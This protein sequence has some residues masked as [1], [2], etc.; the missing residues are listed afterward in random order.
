MR[1]AS[2]TEKQ[3]ET[4]EAH[5]ERA[6]TNLADAQASLLNLEADMEA[7]TKQIDLDTVEENA[8]F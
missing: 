5:K 1:A 8:K 6:A 2:P 7:L 4:A 3:F